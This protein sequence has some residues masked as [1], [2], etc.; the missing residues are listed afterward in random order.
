MVGDSS[1]FNKRVKEENAAGLKAARGLRSELRREVQKQFENR[2]G[3]LR[4][5]T[6]EPK[7][8]RT[9]VLQGI[10]IKAPHYAYKQHYGFTGRKSNGVFMRLQPKDFLQNAAR[11]KSIDTLVDEIS[12][13]R[14]EEVVANINF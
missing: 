9:G 10:T 14:A 8:R 5:I 6:A 1:A 12:A 11:G 3:E 13:I 4:L 7:S 2:S